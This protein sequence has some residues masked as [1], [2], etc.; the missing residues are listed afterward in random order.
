MSGFPSEIRFGGLNEGAVRHK[1]NLAM[2]IALKR[3]IEPLYAYEPD[4]SDLQWQ[5]I[6]AFDRFG[7][8]HHLDVHQMM[9]RQ[10]EFQVC[11]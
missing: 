9:L 5:F 8:V 10:E 11:S 7:G 6:E 3:G 4:G 1:T 2:L